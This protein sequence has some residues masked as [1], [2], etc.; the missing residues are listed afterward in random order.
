MILLRKDS[1]SRDASETADTIAR[2]AAGDR[3]A[4]QELYFAHARYIAGV[5]E[6]ILGNRQDAEDVVQETFTAA[7][8]GLHTVKKPERFRF[9]LVTIAV[10]YA[11]THL[12]RS[13][14]TKEMRDQFARESDVHGSVE[15]DADLCRIYRALDAI[16][17]KLRIPWMLNLVEGF[18]Q[19]EAAELC[20]CSL[21]TVKRR[22][23][24][25]DI[26]IRKR[27]GTP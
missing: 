1:G 23:S 9:W 27:V 12:S 13:Y 14:R 22:I 2:A 4:F 19:E 5:A 3:H 8:R 21:A 7:A 26:Q 15:S 17:A 24:K 25:A 6:R 16:P 11:K 10:R 18:T 20:K